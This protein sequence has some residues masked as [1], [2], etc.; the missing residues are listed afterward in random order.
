MDF[1]KTL[2][3]EEDLDDKQRE[4][5]RRIKDKDI[6]EVLGIYEEFAKEKAD[7]KPMTNAELTFRLMMAEALMRVMA[8]TMEISQAKVAQRLA[9]LE[10][11]MEIASKIIENMA[12]SGP[13]T[14]LPDID[15]KLM[16]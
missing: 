5:L 2:G 10:I 4:F 12:T 15:D 7:D 1:E 6:S 14:S 16:N 8:M 13:D 11:G 9:M 3:K